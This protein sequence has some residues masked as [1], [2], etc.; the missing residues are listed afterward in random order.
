[1]RQRLWPW[2]PRPCGLLRHRPSPHLIRCRCAHRRQGALSRGSL[3]SSLRTC[4]LARL[5]GPRTPRSGPY[6]LCP[7]IGAPGDMRLVVGIS[8]SLELRRL[9]ELVDGKWSECA[10]GGLASSCTRPARI[11]LLDAEALGLGGIRGRISP[12]CRA[13]PAAT[14]CPSGPMPWT[15]PARWFRR[16]DTFPGT[17]RAFR[18]GKGRER[19]RRGVLH[20]TRA[21]RCRL[22]LADQHRGLRHPRSLCRGSRSLAA[23]AASLGRLIGAS[24]RSPWRCGRMPPCASA[25]RSQGPSCSICR[26]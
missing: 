24:A 26:R 13:A 14:I 18:L 20:D 8:C 25:R 16:G 19:L 3:G 21:E 5:G 7:P 22:L 15:L 11:V 9:V 6:S 12:V 17:C 23:P 4:R 2:P 10:P 1:M